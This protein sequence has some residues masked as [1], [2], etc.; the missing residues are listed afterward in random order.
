MQCCMNTFHYRY[1]LLTMRCLVNNLHLRYASNVCNE[2][3]GRVVTR[4]DE[5]GI[6]KLTDIQE[7]VQIIAEVVVE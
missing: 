7:K 4:M 6:R 2:L 3:S 5:L 1:R